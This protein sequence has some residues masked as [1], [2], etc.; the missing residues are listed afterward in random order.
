MLAVQ[1]IDRCSSVPDTSPPPSH[2]TP[3]S[4]F[5]SLPTELR[6]QIY[7]LLLDGKP[8]YCLLERCEISRSYWIPSLYPAILAVN[9]SIS[10][11][12]YPILYGE[13]K[14]LFLGTTSTTDQLDTCHQFLSRLA[15]LPKFHKPSL[16]PQ[17]SRQ[18]I[19]HIVAAPL[20][21]SKPD[22][23][24]Q[25]LELAPAT[26]KIEFD[27]WFVTRQSPRG[28]SILE[29][30]ARL[31]ILDAS[32]PVIKSL[33]NTSTLTFCIGIR[34]FNAYHSARFGFLRRKPIELPSVQ[35]AL[36]DLRGLGN[37]QEKEHEV[38][39][40]LQ[41]IIDTLEQR[42]LIPKKSIPPE[43]ALVGIEKRL[44]LHR[45]FAQFWSLGEL[46]APNESRS[47]IP[48]NSHGQ[49]VEIG[50]E[51]KSITWRRLGTDYAKSK[52]LFGYSYW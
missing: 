18:L 37:V 44:H 43:K 29:P 3:R 51:C 1:C 31:S 17:R 23:I 28:L 10:A 40:A 7:S 32:I 38:D 42:P 45:D 11:E 48:V 12:A 15:G 5:E 19:K 50:S 27:F 39:K 4:R 22:W 52:A 35:L 36:T 41:F 49:I 9:R 13:N 21:L 8:D 2:T 16:L 34:D 33:I 47:W 24:S 25:L 14:F 26:T 6:L 46:T 30:S 20:E